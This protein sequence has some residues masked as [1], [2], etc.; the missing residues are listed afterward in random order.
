MNSEIEC[1][2]S[3]CNVSTGIKPETSVGDV[4]EN[5][6]NLTKSRY[7]IPVVIQYF[8]SFWYHFANIYIGGSKWEMR[9]MGPLCAIWVYEHPSYYHLCPPGD[10]I[11]FFSKIH[12]NMFCLELEWLVFHSL[13]YKIYE[14]TLNTL[15]SFHISFLGHKHIGQSRTP[16]WISTRVWRD[17]WKLYSEKYQINIVRHTTHIIVSWPNQK[18]RNMWQSTYPE[19]PCLHLNNPWIKLT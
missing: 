5:T 1:P 18:H 13:V 15:Q 14:F 10:I 9:C 2:A 11:P 3:Q 7:A 19:L 17:L 12:R 4:S 16:S 8:P 6:D